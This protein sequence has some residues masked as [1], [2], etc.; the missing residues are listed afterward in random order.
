[1]LQRVPPELRKLLLQRQLSMIWNNNKVQIIKRPTAVVVIIIIL[2]FYRAAVATTIWTGVSD[3]IDLHLAVV[4]VV[5]T[6]VQTAHRD[7]D[8]DQTGGVHRKADHLNGVK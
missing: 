5:I 2:P 6:I 4:R 7:H 1:M 3:L 8:R